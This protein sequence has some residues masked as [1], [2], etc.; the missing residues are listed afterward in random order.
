MIF[1]STRSG[2]S[3]EHTQMLRLLSELKAHPL[4]WAFLNPV[5]ADEVPDY[6]GVIKRPMGPY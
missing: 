2:K 4:A 1:Y 3:A 6:Y 5:N